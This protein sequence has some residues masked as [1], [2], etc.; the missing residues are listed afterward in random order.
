M[1]KKMASC[2]EK[3]TSFRSLQQYLGNL[4]RTFVGSEYI[5]FTSLLDVTDVLLLNYSLAFSMAD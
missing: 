1:K 2:S 3:D 5:L 4:T